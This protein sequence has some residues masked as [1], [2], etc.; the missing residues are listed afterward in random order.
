M[1]NSISRKNIS[2]RNTQ[3][4]RQLF[5][6]RPKITAICSKII[7]NFVYFVSGKSINAPQFHTFCSTD[8]PGTSLYASGNAL[9]IHFG[10]DS[11]NSGKGFLIS[12]A[13]GQLLFNN[14]FKRIENV[15]VYQDGILGWEPKFYGQYDTGT[16]PN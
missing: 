11:N 4:P 9:T 10:S 6:L 7:H 14:I 8:K 2:L 3:T 12:V 5:E 13:A 1:G 15:S 16:R